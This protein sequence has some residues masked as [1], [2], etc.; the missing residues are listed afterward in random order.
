M[1]VL[2]KLPTRNRSARAREVLVAAHAYESG[3]NTVKYLIAADP[4]DYDTQSLPHRL[5]FPVE[6]LVK[7]HHSKIEACNSFLDRAREWDVLVLLSD[8]MTPVRQNWDSILV[9]DLVHA[10]PDLDGA[11][12]YDDG[13]VHDKLCTLPIM[14]RRYFDRFGYVY[15]P[16]Y[17]SLWCDN[18]YTE[19]AQ[20]LSR[21]R[22]S[23]QV[24]FRHDHPGNC[25]TASKDELYERNDKFWDTDKDYYGSRKA[26]KFDVQLFD[27]LMCTIP[28]RADLREIV[29]GQL[30]QQIAGLHLETNVHILLEN[31]VSRMTIGVKR[32]ALVARSR[33]EYVAHVDDDDQV[34]DNYVASIVAAIGNCDVDCVGIV[35]SIRIGSEKQDNWM[36]FEHSIKHNRYYQLPDGTYC[37]PPNHLNPIRRSIALQY[38][39]NDISHG[40][41]TDFA[42]RLCRRYA[43][44]T[45]RSTGKKPIYLYL[46]SFW[47][48]KHMGRQDGHASV[49]LTDPSSWPEL[50]QDRRPDNLPPIDYDVMARKISVLQGG[51][52]NVSLQASYIEPV[53][54]GAS[55]VAVRSSIP[56]AKSSEQAPPSADELPPQFRS[57]GNEELRKKI[58]A[59]TKKG[60]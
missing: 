35:G 24:L 22:Y 13:F 27:I 54:Q 60:K 40:E 39:F 41:D 9:S 36:P 12:W 23:N 30:R 28:S 58:Q 52:T 8:D 43:L 32:N 50:E 11:L 1:N 44:L 49:N 34:A 31:D 42:L 4:D 45:E 20:M 2:V 25:A 7:D 53:R 48:A 46:P 5:D 14:G 38:P 33:A 21:I 51:E 56:S 37:R 17:K 3:E 15:E 55:S 18:E 26:H 6:L 59:M 29:E 19:V 47:Y 10:F 16:G 57:T